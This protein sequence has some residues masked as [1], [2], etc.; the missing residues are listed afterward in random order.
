MSKKIN[1]N[2]LFH[3]AIEYNVIM[4]DAELILS[5]RKDIE[6]EIDELQDKFNSLNRYY[7]YPRS[8]EQKKEL[9]L[10]NKEI[11]NLKMSLINKA[12][13]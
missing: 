13:N 1:L 6:F 7:R 9:E 4:T 2:A 10:L 5:D 12:W 8:P 11:T 3:D